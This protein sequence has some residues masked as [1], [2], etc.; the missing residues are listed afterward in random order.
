MVDKDKQIN[1]R[2]SLYTG[3]AICYSGYDGTVSYGNSHGEYESK[4]MGTGFREGDKVSVEVDFLKG[5]VKWF[6]NN[7]QKA[8]TETGILKKR[9]IYFVPYIEMYNSGDQV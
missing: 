3:N 5:S 2:Y 4:E 7:K 9:R 8:F 1:S 6:I